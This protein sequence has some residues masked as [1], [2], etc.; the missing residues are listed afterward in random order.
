MT[1]CGYKVPLEGD[2]SVMTV[3]LVSL[4][5]S[6]VLLNSQV[7]VLPVGEH[8]CTAA[9]TEPSLLR[10]GCRHYMRKRPNRYPTPFFCERASCAVC[11]AHLQHLFSHG[12]FH[13]VTY[14]HPFLK[15]WAFFFNDTAFLGCVHSVF[16]LHMFKCMSVIKQKCL[17]LSKLN[18]PFNHNGFHPR[19]DL[20]LAAIYCFGTVSNC[21]GK[22]C[23][24]C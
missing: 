5:Q 14:P 4:M 7:D 16:L 15:M 22:L 9:L 3:A 23:W 12:L 2:K 18:L 21:N 17:I 6:L 19:V 1:D 13:L 10:L 8:H 20:T 24:P 11:Q